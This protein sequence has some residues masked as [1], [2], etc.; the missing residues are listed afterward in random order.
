MSRLIKKLPSLREDC[1]LHSRN[2]SSRTRLI[3]KIKENKKSKKGNWFLW[4]FFWLGYNEVPTLKTYVDREVKSFSSKFNLPLFVPNKTLWRWGYSWCS[5]YHLVLRV[6]ISD[7]F[8]GIHLK[9]RGCSTDFTQAAEL[10][11]WLISLP[12]VHSFPMQCWVQ[13]LHFV[14]WKL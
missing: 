13:P 12:T 6:S 5:S 14:S 2:P 3:L 4:K 7:D 9:P 11:S 10:R 1:K 8:L